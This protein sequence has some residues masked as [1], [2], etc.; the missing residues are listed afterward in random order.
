MKARLAVLTLLCLAAVPA[1]TMSADKD[2]EKGFSRLFNGKN[3]DRWFGDRAV[4]SVEGGVLHFPKKEKESAERRGTIHCESTHTRNAIVRLEYRA[5][6]GTDS[7]V[8]IHGKKFHIGDFGKLGN[9]EASQAANP[10]GEWNELQFDINDGKAEVMLNGKVIDSSWEIGKH[11][12]KGLG[13]DGDKG[14]I[15][16]RNIRFKE[17]KGPVADKPVKDSRPVKDK[18]V[19]VP[20]PVPVDRPVV[21][22]PDTAPL[23]DKAA[24]DKLAKDKEKVKDKV[25]DKAKDKTKT[26]PAKDSKKKPKS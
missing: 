18:A 11:G 20:V 24:K 9:K 6:E 14:D 26:K 25:K 10:F 13:L 21:V 19:L 15:D 17:T 22:D 2:K 12:N 5:K 3:M 4:W 7:S 8:V 23:K 16:F 1:L